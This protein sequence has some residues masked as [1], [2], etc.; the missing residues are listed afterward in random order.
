MVLAEDDRLTLT[1]T[2]S[3][4]EGLAVADGQNRFP[5][6]P[7]QRLLIEKSPYTTGLIRIFPHNF[8]QVLRDKRDEWARDQYLKRG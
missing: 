1:L 7:G 3:S 5:M 8:Y 4:Q 2:D 6:N